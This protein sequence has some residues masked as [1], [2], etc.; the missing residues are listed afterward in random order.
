MA[1]SS[2]GCGIERRPDFPAHQTNR[3]GSSPVGSTSNRRISGSPIESIRSN[4]APDVALSDNV[5][6]FG[7]RSFAIDCCAQVLL[8]RRGPPYA[9]ATAPRSARSPSSTYGT[10]AHLRA[11]VES[12]DSFRVS[13]AHSHAHLWHLPDGIGL[14]APIGRLVRHPTTDEVCCHVCGRW[15]VALGSH[16]RVHGYSASSYRSTM[17]LARTAPLT[18]RDLSARISQRQSD[19][20][21]T[22]E[23]LREAMRMGHT[24]ARDGALAERVRNSRPF[25]AQAVAIRTAAL[26]AGRATMA[27]RRRADRDLLVTSAGAFSLDDFLRT[28]QARVALADAKAAERVGTD[29]LREWLAARRADGCTLEH[30]ARSTGRSIPWVRSRLPPGT[31]SPSC[32]ERSTAM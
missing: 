28:R 2:R 4:I 1:F 27:A 7:G 12:T 24:L 13:R 32:V 14:H 3:V 22:S 17:G 23:D 5:V 11:V 30:L 6:D 25:R 26:V 16:V 31:G 10:G 15:F 8:A 20:Y 21:R 18:A 9:A 19:R 29:D